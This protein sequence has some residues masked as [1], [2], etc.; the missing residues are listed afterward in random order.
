MKSKKTVC[1][2]LAVFVLTVCAFGMFACASAC[3]HEW[4]DWTVITPETCTT[5]GS[6]ERVCALCG[7]KETQAIPAGHAWESEWT[8]DIAP[9]P[10]STGEK[11]HHCTRCG[12]RKD[13]TVVDKIGP[14]E[15]L[16]YTSTSDGQSYAVTGY[17]REAQLQSIIVVPKEYQ[18]KPVT[19]IG[20]SGLKNTAAKEIYLPDT[21]VRIGD[22]GLAGNDSLRSLTLPASVKE[23][24]EMAFSDNDLMYSVVLPEGL[25][26]IGK[27]AFWNTGLESLTIPASVMSIGTG[28]TLRCRN[29]SEITVAA[30]N[31]TY[32]AAGNCLIEQTTKTLLA[33][34][35]ASVIPTDGSVEIIGEYAFFGVPIQQVVI[36]DSVQTLRKYAFGECKELRSVTI[37]GGLKEDDRRG[38]GWLSGNTGTFE[39]CVNLETLVIREGVKE[40]PARAFANTTIEELVCPDSLE[41]IGTDAF[42]NGKLR[43]V[44]LGKNMK[45]IGGL[46]GVMLEEVRQGSSKFYQVVGDGVVNTQVMPELRLMLHKE[47][48]HLPEQINGEDIW[49]IQDEL[50]KGHTSLKELYIPATYEVLGIGGNN[51]RGLFGNGDLS[52][53]ALTDIYFGGTMEAWNNLIHDTPLPS[54]TVHCTDGDL[55]V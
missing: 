15:G 53:Y 49:K 24:G 50:L 48:L 12:E 2:I 13:I 18:G 42:A 45:D 16:Q 41:I 37:G 54:C 26:T 40:I 32:S 11:S 4:G 36:P 10:T 19:E 14:T 6:Q 23:I 22:Q 46:K 3:Q 39:N 5:D 7:E 34:C 9:T 35:K 38:N 25:E 21:I 55:T 52:E 51:D 1:C 33:G 29:L 44:T 8:I 30:G 27:D 43:V 47:V 20:K 28:V 31:A 17:T